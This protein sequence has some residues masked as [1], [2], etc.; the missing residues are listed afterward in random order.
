MRIAEQRERALGALI[1]QLHLILTNLRDGEPTC[2]FECSSILLGALSRQMNDKRLLHPRPAAPFL[3]HSV[4][5]L[6]RTIR[7][8]RSPNWVLWKQ[9]RIATSDPLS[10]LSSSP[11]NRCK[12]RLSSFTAPRNHEILRGIKGLGLLEFRRSNVHSNM[13][14]SSQ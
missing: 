4:D 10:F 1:S 9:E 5:E 12:C 14:K 6:I 13:D 3:G 11:Q 8:F 7:R 2:S